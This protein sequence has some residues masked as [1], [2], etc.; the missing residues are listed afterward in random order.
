MA[1]QESSVSESNRSPLF[2]ELRGPA[3]AEALLRALAGGF[4][5]KEEVAAA[6]PAMDGIVAADVVDA[7]DALVAEIAG[8]GDSL[9]GLKGAVSRLLN[10]LHRP[11]SAAVGE[12]RDPFFSLLRRESSLALGALEALRAP[13]AALTEGERASSAGLPAGERTAFTAGPPG[14]ERRPQAA[15]ELRGAIAA[16]AP[17]ELHYA[18]LENVLFPYFEAR[19]PRYRCLSLMW[20]IHDD[21]RRSLRVLAGLLGDGSPGPGSDPD[22][23]ALKVAA[24]RLFFDVN[25]LVFREE[26]LLFPL[27][28]RLLQPAELLLLFG[29]AL[30]VGAGFL[31]PS[32][33]ERLGAQAEGYAAA[34]A[35]LKAREAERPAAVAAAAEAARG[36]GEA[37][38]PAATAPSAAPPSEA[39]AVPP[40]GSEPGSSVALDSGALPPLVLDAILKRL[41]LDLTFIDA[42]DKVAYFSNGPHRVF[43]RSP[44]I[45]GRDV[46]NCHPPESLKRVL[47]LIEDFRSGRREREAFW[48]ELRGRFVHIEYFALRGPAGEYLGV[49]EASEDLTDKRALAGEKRLAAMPD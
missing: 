40:S 9:E 31:G 28:A 39:E 4:L 2:F 24:G 13:I 46:R 11:L 42:A 47:A 32:E 29:E 14:A 18:R 44:A 41:P 45:V 38:R 30:A 37:E 15:E 12:L 23:R 5:S 6:M 35:D 20:S 7:V 1:R 33:I 27:A 8:R 19:Y 34:L 3:L 26:R 21:V 10:L 25:A 16:L 49:L 22:P 48:I 17:L 36:G 43:P